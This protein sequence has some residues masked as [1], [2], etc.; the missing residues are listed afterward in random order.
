MVRKE[1][2]SSMNE[3]NKQLDTINKFNVGTFGKEADTKKASIFKAKN[4]KS[5]GKFGSG[6]VKNLKKSGELDF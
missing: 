4:L 1:K 5:A 6:L 2:L 3:L